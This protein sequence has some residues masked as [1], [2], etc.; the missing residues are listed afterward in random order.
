[1]RLYRAA[2]LLGL[3]DTLAV[4]LRKMQDHFCCVK[5]EKDN[6][7]KNSIKSSTLCE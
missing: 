5:G 1:M 6:V 4:L 7:K 3:R 2:A